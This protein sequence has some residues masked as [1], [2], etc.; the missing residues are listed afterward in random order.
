MSLLILKLHAIT[1][2]KALIG[3]DANAFLKDTRGEIF[4]ETP[5]G[6]ACLIITVV[7]FFLAEYKISNDVN[8]SLKLL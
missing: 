8:I 7:G 3:S 6:F 1:P 5:Q 4:V 2:P